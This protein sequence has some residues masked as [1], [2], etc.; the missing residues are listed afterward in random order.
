M[1][2]QRDHQPGGGPA[3]SVREIADLTAR[4]RTLTTAGRDVDPAERAAFLAD[5][6]A[7]LARIPAPDL[8]GGGGAR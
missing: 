6:A 2:T 1:S 7:I 3:P 4:L 5:K 8:D